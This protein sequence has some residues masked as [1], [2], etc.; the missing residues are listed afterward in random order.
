[1]KIFRH[2]SRNII[3]LKPLFS[4]RPPFCGW[5]R[6]FETDLDA[7]KARIDS[8]LSQ[9]PPLSVSDLAVN[10]DDVMTLLGIRPGPEVGEILSQLLDAV[11]ARPEQNQKG[12]LTRLIQTMRKRQ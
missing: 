10:G 7:F 8:L 11:V 4:I 3:N 6:G 5:G 12:E 9:S 2:A 1:M